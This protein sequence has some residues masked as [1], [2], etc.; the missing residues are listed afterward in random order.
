MNKDYSLVEGDVSDP[1]V[2]IDVGVT[3][4]AKTN[5]VDNNLHPRW[6]EVTLCIYIRTDLN[7][8][9]VIE[10]SLRLAFLSTAR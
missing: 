5:V 9:R 10:R 2:T 8:R 4:V 6:N 1:Y 3:R 7:Y